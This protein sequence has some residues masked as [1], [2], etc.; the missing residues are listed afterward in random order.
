MVSL[1]CLLK[2]KSIINS[3]GHKQVSKNLY[4]KIIKGFKYKI[5][6]PQHE[7]E[8]SYSR[9]SG[10]GGQNVNKLNTKVE[11]RINL[12]KAVSNGWLPIIV[13]NRI[14]ENNGNKINNNQELVVVCQETRSQQE[15]KII[16]EEKIRKIIEE[17][18]DIKNER[19]FDGIEVSEEDKTKREREKKKRSLVKSNRSESKRIDF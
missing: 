4:S 7:F 1:L 6:I 16:A 13:K 3:I 19:V 11:L 15:N 14:I 9:S 12:M 18:C 10:P 8:F 5:E 17:A 2:H